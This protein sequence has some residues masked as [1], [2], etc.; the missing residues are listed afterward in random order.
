MP[1]TSTTVWAAA[2]VNTMVA[3]I[4]AGAAFMTGSSAMLAEAIHTA[5]DTANEVLLLYGMRRARHIPD[6]T[7]PF[8]YGREMYFWS[9]VVAVLVF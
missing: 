5:V 7:H 2:F 4:K 8:G 1:G 6:A 3:V 9:F